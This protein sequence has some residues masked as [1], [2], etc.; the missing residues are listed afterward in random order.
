MFRIGCTSSCYLALLAAFVPARAFC[1]SAPPA[2]PAANDLRV[3]DPSL[4]DK[5]VP[6]FINLAKTQAD[7][8]AM[9][10]QVGIETDVKAYIASLLF[11]PYGMGGILQTGRYDIAFDGWVAGADPDNSSQFLCSARPPNGSVSVP[12]AT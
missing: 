8:Q 9:L 6:L 11:A 3:F 7:R 2:A 5:S 1:Q 12:M 4:I 10:R